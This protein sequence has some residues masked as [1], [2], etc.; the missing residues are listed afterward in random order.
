MFVD[1]YPQRQ[2]KSKDINLD[3]LDDERYRKLGHAIRYDDESIRDL[4]DWDYVN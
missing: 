4:A 2:L 3:E 1:K